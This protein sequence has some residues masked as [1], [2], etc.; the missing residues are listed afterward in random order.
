MVWY[1]YHD[2][3]ML[4]MNAAVSVATCISSAATNIEQITVE[5]TDMTLYTFLYADNKLQCHTKSPKMI[6]LLF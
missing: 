1:L 6:R 2:K 5:Y 4:S 3:F